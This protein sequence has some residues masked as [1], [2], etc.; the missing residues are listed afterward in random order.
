MRR[1]ISLVIVCCGLTSSSASAQEEGNPHFGFEAGVG[2][3]RL[4]NSIADTV[5][6]RYRGEVTGWTYAL[7][8][9]HFHGNGAPS[10]SLQLLLLRLDGEGRDLRAGS[11][12]TANAR[13]AGFL[14]TKYANIVSR[15]RGS[16]GFGFGAGVGPQFKATYRRTEPFQGVTLPER[17]YTLKELPVTP[18][19]QIVVAGDIRLHRN[20]SF[21]PYVGLR[22]GLL[23]YGGMFR[24]RFVK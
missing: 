7:G 14:A 11:L 13:L 9:T 6:D 19:F 5:Q 16:I 1:Y 10:Y 20:L 21:G 15:S 18:L 24:G 23:V 17:T 8:L 12:Y 2:Y 4:P 3:A 22:N